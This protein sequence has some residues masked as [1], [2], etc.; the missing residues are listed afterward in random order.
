MNMNP[1]LQRAVQFF[2][3]DKEIMSCL[4]LVCGADGRTETAL[5]GDAGWNSVFDL[6]SLTK[7]FTGLCAM[8]LKEEGLLDL[9]RP[10]FSYDPRF[11]GLKDVTVGELMA[12]AVELRT[13]GRVD[14]F[15][16]GGAGLAWAGVGQATDLICPF[17]ML[18]FVAAIAN[19]GAAAEPTLLAGARAEKTPLLDA[20]TAVELK[21]MMRFNVA[22]AYGEAN[23]PGLKL[24]AKSGTAETG[25]GT[26]H[27]WFTGF[28]DDPAHPYAFVVLIENGGSGARN[29]GPAANAVL[30]KA[31]QLSDGETSS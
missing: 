20:E 24:C 8:K 12:F 23:F 29:A 4:L 30:Q 5:D 22:A 18:R 6:A 15:P 13:P 21:S 16:D 19:S 17:A 7:L 14:A 1:E 9:S 28:L 26:S 10:V 2:T 27:A 25:G 3:R 31:I 11:T